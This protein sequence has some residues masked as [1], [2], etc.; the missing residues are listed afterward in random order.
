MSIKVKSGGAYADIV[1][2]FV[3]QGGVYGAA[4][5][6]ARVAGAY[7]AVGGGSGPPT[8]APLYDPASLFALGEDGMLY[9]PQRIETLW[10]DTAGT[11]PVTADGQL[12]ARIDDRSGNGYHLT[13]ATPANQY[14]YKDVDGVKWLDSGGRVCIY[15]SGKPIGGG[16]TVGLAFRQALNAATRNFLD[17]GAGSSA[18]VDSL[19]YDTQGGTGVVR[20]YERGN[21]VGTQRVGPALPDRH[22]AWV[23]RIPSAPGNTNHVIFGQSAVLDSVAR[24]PGRTTSGTGVRLGPFDACDFRWY[25]VCFIAREVSDTERSDLLGYLAQIGETETPYIWVGDAQ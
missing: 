9:D 2:A 7:Q 15:S 16:Y 12:V 14:V 8:P 21:S 10:Q 4:S 5:V 23:S 25:G 20:Y 18:A 19:Y 17:T 3:K 22:I 24:L 13:Q 6:F 11:V 1:G